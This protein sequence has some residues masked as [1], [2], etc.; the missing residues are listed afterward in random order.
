MLLFSNHVKMHTLRVLLSL[1][2]RNMLTVYKK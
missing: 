2:Y 1:S